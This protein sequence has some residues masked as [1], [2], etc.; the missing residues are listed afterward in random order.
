[1]QTALTNLVDKYWDSPF[2]QQLQDKRKEDN[3]PLYTA[4]DIVDHLRR[5]FIQACW[6]RIWSYTNQKEKRMEA[7]PAKMNQLHKEINVIL[8]SWRWFVHRRAIDEWWRRN[9]NRI[10]KEQIEA[11]SDDVDTYVPERPRR[12][13]VYDDPDEPAPRPHRRIVYDDPDEPVPR[14]RRRRIVYDDPTIDYDDPDE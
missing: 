9:K 3:A 7:F 5:R 2:I 4:E 12:R 8:W 11:Y 1:M 10:L 13:I 14:P 6:K